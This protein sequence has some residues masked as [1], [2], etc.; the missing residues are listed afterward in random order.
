MRLLKTEQTLPSLSLFYENDKTY[1][2][3]TN[4]AKY[5]VAIHY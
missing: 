5:L 4:S 2:F 1:R 3:V